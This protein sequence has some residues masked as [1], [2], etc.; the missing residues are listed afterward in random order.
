[1]FRKIRGIFVGK[2]TRERNVSP[3]IFLR[4]HTTEIFLKDS[5][6]DKGLH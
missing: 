1:M 2:Y 3:A 4:M 6:V 5:L